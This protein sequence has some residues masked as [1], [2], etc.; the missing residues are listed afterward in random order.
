[1]EPGCLHYAAAMSQRPLFDPSKMAAARKAVPAA[2]PGGGAGSALPAGGT[3]TVSQLAA[4]VSGALE[5]GL[6]GS[7][8]VIGQVGGARERTHWYFDLKDS[9]AVVACVMFASNVRRLRFVPAEGLEVVATG[10]VEFYAKQGRLTLIVDRLEP[11]GAGAMELAYRALLEEI[12]GLGW[13]DGARKR[14]LPAFPRRIAVL[15]SRT[16]AALQDVMDTALRRFP[17]LELVLVDVRVQGDGAAEEIAAALR[18]VGRRRDELGLDAVLI[19]RGGGSRE[20]LWAF[21]ERVLAAAIVESPLPVVAAI[22]HETDTTIAELVADLRAATPTQAVMRLT[23]DAAALSEQISSME[24]RLRVAIERRLDHQWTLEQL[25]RALRAAAGQAVLREQERVA[26]LGTMLERHRPVAVLARRGA[27]ILELEARLRATIGGRLLAADLAGQ[28]DRLERAIGQRLRSA[29]ERLAS[30][31]RHLA[32]IGPR[33]VLERGYS[34]TLRE[35]G[36][37]VRSASD[38]RAGDRL[39]TRLAEGEVRSIVDG[40]G[41]GPQGRRRAGR[42]DERPAEESAQNPEQMDLFDVGR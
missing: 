2:G 8:R 22:G 32:S 5:R 21:N 18:W 41:H 3:L 11:V 12:R 19:T 36:R 13:L 28:A 15:T 1:M 24:R 10:R 40:E 29:H 7:V 17:P 33:A 37:L 30:L 20:D 27:T 25:A 35:D 39:R 23:P 14:P 34:Y 31:G 9:S 4:A 38:V 6:P 16:G 42:R 26:R